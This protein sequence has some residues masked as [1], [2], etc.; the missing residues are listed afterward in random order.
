MGCGCLIAL[1]AVSVP[2]FTLFSMWLFTDTLTIAFDSFI[3]GFLGFLVLPYTTAIYALVYAPF[4]GV[5]GFGWILVGFGVLLDLSSYGSS[6]QARR[7]RYAVE[8]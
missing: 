4:G 1:L 3:M 6:E 7:Q 5:S 8:G 2:R